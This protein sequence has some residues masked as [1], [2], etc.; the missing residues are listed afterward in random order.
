MSVTFVEITADDVTESVQN[1]LVEA[2]NE[3]LINKD[4]LVEGAI[5]GAKQEALR[6]KQEA[7]RDKLN[8]D[9]TDRH[10]VNVRSKLNEAEVKVL[11]LGI[12][13][14][15]LEGEEGSPLADAK[16]RLNMVRE[17][18]E[19]YKEALTRALTCIP[20]Y[21]LPKYKDLVPAQ[22]VWA[23]A[24]KVTQMLGLQAELAEKQALTKPALPVLKKGS[25]NSSI[26]KHLSEFQ[27]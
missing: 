7:G 19:K 13:L 26:T 24:P 6:W 27:N 15:Y 5:L 12:R 2:Y 1:T 18:A 22:E 20:V 17:E 21:L 25:A 23:E 10:L 16:D 9:N 8:L 3:G 14:K 4:I 11:N